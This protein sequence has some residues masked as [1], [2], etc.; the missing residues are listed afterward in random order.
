M[1][2]NQN[3]VRINEKYQVFWKVF[4]KFMKRMDGKH[5]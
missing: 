5:L 1:K 3:I 4:Q 2:C